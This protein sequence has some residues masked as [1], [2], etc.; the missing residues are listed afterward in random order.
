M[1]ERDYV[2]L[3]EVLDLINLGA[4]VR[5]ANSSGET[6]LAVA[7]R[8]GHHADVL[9]LLIQ[10][11]A[12]PSRNPFILHAL[13]R[14]GEVSGSQV[15]ALLQGDAQVNSIDVNGDSP[16]EVAVKSGQSAS[17]LKVLLFNGAS[18]AAAPTILHQLLRSDAVN[19]EMVQALL[20]AGIS[21]TATDATGRTPLDIAL[22]HG[23]DL[24]ILELLGHPTA[25]ARASTPTQTPTATPTA[26]PS[27]PIVS[28]ENR[29]GSL[30]VNPNDGYVGCPGRTSHTAFVAESVL[31]FQLE[32]D[33]WVPRAQRWSIGVLYHAPRN[34]KDD[35]ATMIYADQGGP[36]AHHWVREGGRDIGLSIRERIDS[37]V[38]DYSPGDVNL[39]SFAND[40]NETTVRV[41]G[42][43]VL[44]VP[45]SNLRPQHG[46]LQLCVGFLSQETEPYR[47]DYKRLSAEAE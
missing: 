5:A 32:V 10:S 12:D 1:L 15:L 2:S 23:L 43:T 11:G 21:E 38:I 40:D 36:F 19:V 46:T 33:F 41:N 22:E 9:S 14:N 8:R 7:A 42:A 31:E 3:A 20:N 47:I 39:V 37:T 6:P 16:L 35:T 24:A 45:P 25:E 4:P 17:V 44:T 34:S 30:Y 18:L 26:S 13:L 29:E 27:R 28:I